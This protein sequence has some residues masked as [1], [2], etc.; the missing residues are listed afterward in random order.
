MECQQFQNI[1][2][3]TNSSTGRLCK[4]LNEIVVQGIYYDTFKIQNTKCLWF[5][6]D[7]FSAL[8]KD[9]LLGGSFALYPSYVAEILHTV[10][11]I[12]FYMLCNKRCHYTQYIEMCIA[13]KECA[14]TFRR[15]SQIYFD[16]YPDEQH[17]KLLYGGKTVSVSI[18]TRLF[19]E[20]PSELVFAE[21]IK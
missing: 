9:N 17:F 16:A 6:N 7:I 21:C 13:G 15:L 4:N 1:S 2:F 11:E 5:V 18:Q 10:K 12:R 19:P 20:L 14:I 3:S 8:N